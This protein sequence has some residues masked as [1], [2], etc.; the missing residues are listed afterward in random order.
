MGRNSGIV[1]HGPQAKAYLAATVGRFGLLVTLLWVLQGC[2]ASVTAADWDRAVELCQRNDGVQRVMVE[3]VYC[4][5]GAE[6]DW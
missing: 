6:F 5:D 1:T 3:R 2:M 4:K